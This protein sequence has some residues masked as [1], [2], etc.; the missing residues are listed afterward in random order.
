MTDFPL[1]DAFYAAYNRHDADAATALYALE[2]RHDEIAMGKSRSGHDALR[3]G[4]NGFFRMLPDVSWTPRESVRSAE[5]IA[6]FYS[7]TG[8]FT[9][10]PTEAQ[11]APAPK[12]VE[13]DGMHLFKFDG[14][15][16]VLTQD[17]WDKD[18]FMAQIG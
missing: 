3:D 10:R 13:L 17:Y 16:I 4:L 2:G 6:I 12:A 11:P 5:H 15:E 8:T 1:V 14:D 7:M 18:Q 9:P